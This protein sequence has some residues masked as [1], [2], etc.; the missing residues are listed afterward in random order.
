[1]NIFDTINPDGSTTVERT[2]YKGL[3]ITEDDMSTD[4]VRQL[5]KQIYEIYDK[6]E[7]DIV[8][9]AIADGFTSASKNYQ[10]SDVQITN[11][12]SGLLGFSPFSTITGRTNNNYGFD[13]INQSFRIILE[14]AF[15]EVPMLPILGSNLD[16]LLFEPADEVLEENLINTLQKALH[17]LEPRVRILDIVVDLDRRD[18]NFV[19]VSITYQL[20]N[21]NI[22]HIFRDTIITDAGGDLTD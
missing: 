10:L 18:E 3:E 16:S 2:Y 9:D 12:G 22:V 7:G 6:I 17:A 20:T 8:Y 13:R 15:E 11:I 19:G 4:A 1:M 21:T 5:K 14:T